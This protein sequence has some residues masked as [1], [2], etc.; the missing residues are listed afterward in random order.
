MEPL[1]DLIETQRRQLPWIIALVIFYLLAIAAFILG[2][3]T[4]TRW[5]TL[6]G[7]GLIWCGAF[8]ALGMYWWITHPRGRSR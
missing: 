3:V 7:V 1:E 2:A 6:T 4:D 5:M 8:A